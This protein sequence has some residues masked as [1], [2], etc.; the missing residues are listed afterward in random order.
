MA[1]SNKTPVQ[2]I[3]PPSGGMMAWLQQNDPVASMPS[4]DGEAL[5]EETAPERV[6]NSNPETPAESSNK[7]TST[8]ESEDTPS[9]EVAQKESEVIIKGNEITP[10]TD[11]AENTSAVSIPRKPKSKVVGEGAKSSSYLETFFKKPV[12]ENGTSLASDGKPVRITEESHYLL[13]VLVSEARR[14]GYKLNAGDLIDNLLTHHRS[15]HKSEVD[16]LIAKW[17]ARKRFE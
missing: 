5:K 7:V 16:E 1:K 11:A 12:K 9:R 2:A 8:S 17:K 3:N 4:S 14:Q 6:E 13:S 15:E 10:A